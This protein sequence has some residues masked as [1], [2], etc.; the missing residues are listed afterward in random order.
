MPIVISDQR[1]QRG[2]RRKNEESVGRYCV[3]VWLGYSSGSDA[4]SNSE[5]PVTACVKMPEP[6]YPW[7]SLNRSIPI[8]VVAFNGERVSGPVCSTSQHRIKF[9]PVCDAYGLISTVSCSQVSK[10]QEPS[11]R[12]A[13]F[14]PSQDAP[15]GLRLEFG[16]G[17]DFGTGERPNLRFPRAAH[18]LP[19]SRAGSP[20]CSRNTAA[21]LPAPVGSNSAR[22]SRRW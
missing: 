12:F 3:T 11:A 19:A 6:L 15:A 5:S 18:Y 2:E 13:T 17:P 7:Y 1:F 8:P 9:A 10:S 4:V 22:G 14:F 21:R 20:P 16:N